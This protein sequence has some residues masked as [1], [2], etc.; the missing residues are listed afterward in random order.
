MAPFDGRSLT[1]N[2]HRWGTQKTY[3]ASYLI[4]FFQSHFLVNLSF[5]IVRAYSIYI[6][7][8]HPISHLCF[9]VGSTVKYIPWSQAS[10]PG[11]FPSHLLV[12]WSSSSSSFLMKGWWENYSQI[13]VKGWT[14]FL[15]IH[16]LMFQSLVSQNVTVF[17]IFKEVIE[18]KWGHY[19]GGLS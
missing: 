17:K 14:V 15:K 9:C 5:F 3:P 4:F 7:F 16:M 11:G 8:S 19:C 12:D 2:H 6:L 1:P 18:L 10:L 13:V